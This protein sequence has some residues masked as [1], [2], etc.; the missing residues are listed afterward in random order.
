M[1]LV[2]VGYQLYFQLYSFDDIYAGII[3]YLLRIP[4][5]HNEAFVFW[6]RF[7]DPEEWRSGKVLAAHGYPHNRLLE[8]YPMVH[9]GE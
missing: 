7:V 5:K 9:A 1:Q 2:R 6:S 8:E 4:P 3:A